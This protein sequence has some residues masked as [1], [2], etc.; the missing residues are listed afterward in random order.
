MAKK[1]F[2][3]EY[4][5]SKVSYTA[6]T[7]EKAAA[8]DLVLDAPDDDHDYLRTAVFYFCHTHFMHPGAAHLKQYDA[9]TRGRKLQEWEYQPNGTFKGWI[10]A[11]VI[12]K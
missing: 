2:E 1:S 9:E 12:E 5:K 7:L 10:Y 6:E 11:R 4:K 3:V 8:G